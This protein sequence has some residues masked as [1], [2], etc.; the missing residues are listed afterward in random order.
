M[1]TAIYVAFASFLALGLYPIT[2]LAAEKQ[3]KP[4]LCTEWQELKGPAGTLILCT[5]RKTPVVLTKWHRVTMPDK[6]GKLRPYM[7]G[8]R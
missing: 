8:W 3:P 5:D 2:L 4:Q 7:L 1:K 6:D